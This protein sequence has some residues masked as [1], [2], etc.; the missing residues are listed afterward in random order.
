MNDHH[1]TLRRRAFL[2]VALSLPVAPL[3]VP[4]P[5]TERERL[6]VKLEDILDE[7]DR[8]YGRDQR[9]ALMSR[10]HG[11]SLR[12]EIWFGGRAYFQGIAQTYSPAAAQ[13]A[14]IRTASGRPYTV[15]DLE[16]WA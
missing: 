7:L 10:R 4:Q 8:Q 15:A 14:L 16:R 11:M 13:C 5:L 2:T 9:I 1:R 12:E 3:A 6:L